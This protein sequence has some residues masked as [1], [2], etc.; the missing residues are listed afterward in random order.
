FIR[1]EWYVIYTSFTVALD[2]IRYCKLRSPFRKLSR[3]SSRRSPT[4]E[5]SVTLG[6]ICL[7]HQRRL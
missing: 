1:A 6:P 7:M 4:S 2:W 5:Q 3:K